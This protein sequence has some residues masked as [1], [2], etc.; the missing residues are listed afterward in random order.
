MRINV[1]LLAAGAIFGGLIL[2]ADPA[3]A[4]LHA[5]TPRSGLLKS[6]VWFLKLLPF[7]ALAGLAVGLYAGWRARQH[8]ERFDSDGMVRRH[9]PLTILAHWINA[10]GILICIGTG[11]IQYRVVWWTAPLQQVYLVHFIGASMV[12]FAVALS[13]ARQVC[14]GHY[15]VL[16][17]HGD[18]RA[19]FGQ[20]LSGRDKGRS[21]V[22]KY[23]P[24]TR[25][26]SFPLWVT[27]LA[28]VI[29]TGLLKAFRYT[30][31][32][33][34]SAVYVISAVHV[35][36]LFLASAKLLEHLV[37]YLAVPSQWP[38][39]KSMFG[40]T[41]PPDYVQR[42][43]PAWYRELRSEDSSVAPAGQRD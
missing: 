9:A 39:L 26:V 37:R 22:G 4:D 8:Q 34:G 32:L 21:D 13:L 27:I 12:V 14:A 41:L 42:W 24:Y 3:A 18:L 16:W 20:L 35:A 1:T 29:I 15:S 19:L 40:R 43:H 6:Q 5:W 25:V 11:L 38:L 10:L 31:P 28:L 2:L 7:V 33:P 30:Y 17:R 23:S 36:T